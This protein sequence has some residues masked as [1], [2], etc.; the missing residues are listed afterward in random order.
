MHSNMLYVD[1]VTVPDI[2]DFR[3]VLGE[4]AMGGLE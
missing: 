4:G 1:E 2:E 3:G